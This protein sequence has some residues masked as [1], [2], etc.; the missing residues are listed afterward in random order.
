MAATAAGGVVA[1]C[2]TSAGI[3]WHREREATGDRMAHVPIYV[4]DGCYLLLIS[5]LAS[6][7]KGLKASDLASRV[8]KGEGSEGKPLGLR[9]PAPCGLG[10]GVRP[11]GQQV[12]WQ[13]GG[14]GREPQ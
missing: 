11:I 10:W 3:L 5:D 12:S 9:T 2:A 1:A 4:L 6:G 13:E 7:E 14:R 8:L